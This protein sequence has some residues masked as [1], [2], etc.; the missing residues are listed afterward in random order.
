MYT[1]RFAHVNSKTAAWSFALN[2]SANYRRGTRL[3]EQSDD[4]GCK[5]KLYRR[6][7]AGVG[8]QYSIRPPDEDTIYQ[9]KMSRKVV[10]GGVFLIEEYIIR[11]V[12]ITLP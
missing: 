8:G 6:K 7:A 2:L 10:A 12:Y 11:H 9:S 1:N 3:N 4:S 5:E